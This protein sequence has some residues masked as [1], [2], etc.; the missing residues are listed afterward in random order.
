MLL[1]QGKAM[2]L[3]SH[4]TKGNCDKDGTN[5]SASKLRVNLLSRASIFCQQGDYAKAQSV[6][7]KI[8]SGNPDDIDALFGFGLLA[9]TLKQ[10]D[11]AFTI[12]SK[13]ISLDR[14][15]CQ[16][17]FQRGRIYIQ[18]KQYDNAITDFDCALSIDPD[19]FEAI[20]SRGIAHS[21]QLDFDS[22][23][24]DFCKAVK[25]R[26][27]SSDAFY[28]RA[29]AHKN[30]NKFDLAVADYTQAIEL[31][32]NHFQAL[33][34]RGM[35]FRELRQF[36]KAIEDFDSCI[37]LKADFADGYWN[38]ALTHLM[39]GDYENAWRLY[40]HRWD[41]PNFTSR[42]RNFDKPLWLGSP[43]LAGK[44]I[45][46]HSEQGLGDS[47]QVSRYI[48]KF[49]ELSCTVLL[50]VERPL[51]RIMECLLPATQI[52]EKD[53]DLPAFDFH[54]PLMSLP[55]AFQTSVKTIPF[56]SSYLSAKP[57]RVKWWQDY[58]GKAA[59]PRIGLTWRGN[60]DNRN[61]QRRSIEL[62][63]I[64]HDLSPDFDWYSLQ[65]EVSDAEECMINN[66][67]HLTHFGS[68]IGDFAETAAF[69][70]VLD[71]VIC[72]DTS[73]A[74]LCGAIGQP[75]HLLLSYNADSRWHACGDSTPWY[76]S[77]RIH[78]QGADRRWYEPLQCAITE[79]VTSQECLKN[80]QH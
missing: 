12:F 74:H 77:M 22:A 60:P 6:Y 54:C 59:K 27:Q 58:L 10:R 65:M 24:S 55:L 32:P 79:I 28:N 62:T 7:K 66:I 78:R 26:P 11:I 17:F 71:T 30:L 70:A 20:S 51:M 42:K 5:V 25:I 57:D 9:Q 49:E 16:A 48:K 38:K 33:N 45:L 37:A 1:R 15:H 56:S 39:I 36:D 31:N 14:E 64:I 4:N 63:D 34:N 8:L 21:K 73:I 80:P 68:L 61:D 46:L 72:V 23:L 29:L 2:T 75:V 50:E 41:S 19:F 40:E 35:A 52:I 18:K 47:L 67:N 13:I 44:T 69:C 76:E 3:R 43:S 53:S